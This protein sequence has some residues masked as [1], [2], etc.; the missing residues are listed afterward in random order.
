MKVTPRQPVLP[1]YSPHPQFLEMRSFRFN[2]K[3]AV[4][5]ILFGLFEELRLPH[6]Q[7]IREE[8]RRFTEESLAVE[9]KRVLGFLLDGRVKAEYVFAVW[10]YEEL[11]LDAVVEALSQLTGREIRH[12]G[13][14]ELAVRRKI[15]V[16]VVLFPAQPPASPYQTP[17]IYLDASDLNVVLLYPSR[18]LDSFIVTRCKHLYV[19]Y[20]LQAQTKALAN[21]LISRSSQDVSYPCELP[22]CQKPIGFDVFE[23][24]SRAQIQ[25]SS[26]YFDIVQNEDEAESFEQYYREVYEGS[27]KCQACGVRIGSFQCSARCAICI[28]CA[29]VAYCAYG[30]SCRCP[31]CNERLR[32]EFCM[33]IVEEI[34]KRVSWTPLPPPITI[35]DYCKQ[36]NRIESIQEITYGGRVTFSCPACFT[37]SSQATSPRGLRSHRSIREIPIPMMDTPGFD[38]SR[39]SYFST[40]SLT[41]RSRA[42]PLLIPVKRFEGYVSAC[43]GDFME[44]CLMCGRQT[45]CFMVM[46]ALKHDCWVCDDCIHAL[47][48]CA[49]SIPTCFVCDTTV[50]P[51]ALQ[52]IMKWRKGM[53]SLKLMNVPVNCPVCRLDKPKKEHGKSERLN[54]QCTICDSCLVGKRSLTVCPACQSPYDQQDQAVVSLFLSNA[55]VSRSAEPSPRHSRL[56]IECNGPI[57]PTN[58]QCPKSCLCSQCILQNYVFTNSNKCPKCKSVIRGRLPES[59]YCTACSR[60]LIV[61]S[62]S[63]DAVCAVCDNGCVLCCFCVKISKNQAVSCVVC[64]APV[65]SVEVKNL[66]RLQKGFKLGCYCGREKGA[67]ISM[68]CGCKAHGDCFPRIRSCRLCGRE[69]KNRGELLRITRYLT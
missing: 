51:A 7:E 58:P 46:Q 20:H 59:V 34:P 22:R 55:P 41:M 29:L 11:F 62:E 19:K 14:I 25:P 52:A 13:D 50:G 67:K 32:K 68:P 38:D 66:V 6:F 54:H 12:W 64:S 28:E 61:E 18:S 26:I 35:C 65:E 49:K 42:P 53:N 33:L 24:I 31:V 3:S 69:Y 10:N 9:N 4:A 45:S 43:L 37:S 48:D 23:G 16:Q 15:P 47:Y 60:H 56:C 44:K 39:V 5:A 21:R 27:E 2:A 8:L 63:I 1:K 30:Y 57:Q 40:T 17:T 36:P